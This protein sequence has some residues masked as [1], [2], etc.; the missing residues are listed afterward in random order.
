MDIF[1]NL[2]VSKPRAGVGQA[3]WGEEGPSKLYLADV[4]QTGGRARVEVARAW[5]SCVA[6]AA[7]DEGLFSSS[8]AVE[9][10]W[11]LCGSLILTLTCG[12]DSKPRLC[13]QGCSH[14]GQASD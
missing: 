3:Q 1:Q 13:W 6:P 14:T 9:P 12:P 2:P 11:W 7:Q 8:C 4:M 5:V 10:A